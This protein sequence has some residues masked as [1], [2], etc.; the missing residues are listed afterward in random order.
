VSFA[1]KQEIEFTGSVHKVQGDQRG[2]YS[3][4]N[5]VCEMATALNEDIGCQL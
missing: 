1:Q 4:L 2:G 3:N 5:L